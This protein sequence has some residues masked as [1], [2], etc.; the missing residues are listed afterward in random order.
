[1]LSQIMLN[2]LPEWSLYEPLMS[3]Q[4][5]RTRAACDAVQTANGGAA[6]IAVFSEMLAVLLGRGDCEAALRLE[7]F[8]HRTS[9]DYSVAV[10]CAYPIEAF[11][12][13]KDAKTFL[14]ICDQHSAVDPDPQ[15]GASAPGEQESRTMIFFRQSM[16]AVLAELA[17]RRNEQRF[18]LFV[19]A[20]Q[21]YALFLLDAEGRVSTWN[22][23]AQRIK[24]YEAHEIIGKHFSIFYP[25]SDVLAGKPQFELEIAAR[26]GRFED[27]GWRVRK[28]GSKFWAN[29]II[30]ALRDEHGVLYGFGK[31]TRDFTERMLAQEAQRDAQRKLEESEKS[32]RELSLHQFRMQEEER[33]RIGIEL[34]DS[35]GQNLSFLKIALDSMMSRLNGDRGS[36]LGQTLAECATVAEEAVREVRTVSYLLYPPMLEEMGLRSAVSWYIEGFA[37]HS[38]IKTELSVCPGLGRLPRD[39]ETAVFR[40]LQEALTN[41][42]RH[43]GSATASVRIAIRDGNLELEVSDQGKGIV[44]P[45]G[46]AERDWTRSP[47]VGL[48]GM[49]E[50]MRQ[51]GGKL[52]LMLTPVGSTVK[53]TVPIA[54]VDA[55]RLATHP[56]QRGL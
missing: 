18:R 40:V 17:L 20:V 56:S 53:A 42:H 14:R 23:G 54:A 35:L 46:K 21:D 9:A 27:E 1:M 16:Q 47:G 39:I 51:L 34:H 50:R 26:E 11:G 15:V 33:R 28:D 55:S 10:L 8:G 31:V 25:E 7:R 48:R 43:S 30:T 36:S 37:Q 12:S 19:E 44:A 29:V 5:A 45:T 49:N 32:L 2:G 4:V 24:G 52:E 38:G 41:V 22:N 6:P 13:E 3:A